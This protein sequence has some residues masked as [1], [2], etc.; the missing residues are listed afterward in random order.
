MPT[1]EVKGFKDRTTGT[2]YALNDETARAL[3]AKAVQ[4]EAQ[5]LTSEQKAQAR[6]N[7]GAMGAT[8]VESA[9]AATNGNVTKLYKLATIKNNLVSDGVANLLGATITKNGTAADSNYGSSGAKYAFDLPAFDKLH[10]F[11]RYRQ[12][13][14]IAYD[15]VNDTKITVAEV[16]GNKAL[17]V[18]ELDRGAVMNSG[19][20]IYR[21]SYIYPCNVNT[22]SAAQLLPQYYN[23]RQGK[24]AL[25]VRYTGDAE[26]GASSSVKMTVGSGTL[27]F[28]VDGE[29]VGEAITYTSETTIDTLAAAI[30]ELTGFAAE[31]IDS[32]GAAGDLLLPSGLEAEMVTSFTPNGGSLTYD[33]NAIEIPFAVDSEWHTCEF[34]VDK[35]NTYAAVA[36]DGL[37]KYIAFGSGKTLADNVLVVGGE[38]IDIRDL[39]IDLNSFGDCELISAKAY[40]GASA[41]QYQLISAHNPRLMIFEGHG[42]TAETEAEAQAAYAEAG[43]GTEAAMTASTDRLMQVFGALKARGYVPVSMADVVDWKLGRKDLPKRCYVV[44]FDDYRID[45]YLDY[46]LRTPMVKYGVKAAL[47]LITDTYAL[48]AE[49]EVNGETMTVGDALDIINL[50]GWFP[51][52]HTAGHT[53][54]TD[55]TEQQ[56]TENLEADVLSAEAHKAHGNV[57]VYPYGALTTRVLPVIG[58]SDFAL[59]VDITAD[60]YNCKATIN[61]RLTRTELGTRAALA[62]VLAPFA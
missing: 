33:T 6:T 56:L 29:T 40:D 43:A 20:K 47:S 25:V 17:N 18:Q 45:N 60:R 38:S 24:P 9:I 37:T 34:I 46:S 50:A 35:T 61:E 53:R 7:I 28:T 5:E 3:A 36:Y 59:G 12:A 51:C 21:T 52:S 42:V 54:M 26:L 10:V 31:I 32:N 11:F 57:I 39:V 44:V 16:G 14:Y 49:H 22:N 19:G 1:P 30:N 13:G 58:R 15:G 48:S 27:T 55:Y 23:A 8:D 41:A 62:D 4:F 2:T